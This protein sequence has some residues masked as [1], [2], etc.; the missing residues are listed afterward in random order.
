MIAEGE[1]NPKVLRKRWS[2]RKW[3]IVIAVVV[4]L[5]YGAYR[6]ASAAFLIFVGQPVRIEGNTMSPA[7]NDGDR[8]FI[9]KTVSELKRG[10]IVVFRHPQEATKSFLKRIIALPGDHISLSTSG[11]LYVNQERVQEPYVSAERNRFP[12]AI[13]EQFIK[14]NHYFVMGDNRD[15]SNDS[16]SF[17]AIPREL[18][19]G[20]VVYRYWP[21]PASVK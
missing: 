4:V 15:G 2:A 21:D 12:K 16:R 13:Q 18:I 9:D 5:L 6:A 20:K 7:L 10:D 19:Y 8:L 14:E 11:D 17:G 1:L 3:L